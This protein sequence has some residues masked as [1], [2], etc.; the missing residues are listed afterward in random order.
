MSAP[1]TNPSASPSAS[2]SVEIGASADTAYAFVTDL[3][4]MATVTAEAVAMRW[5]SGT[6]ATPGAVFKGR[7]RNGWRRWSTRCEVTDAEPGRTFAFEVSSFG[8]PVARWQ[9]DVEPLGADRCRVTES[10]WDQRPAWFKGPAGLATG[11]PDRDAGNAAHIDETLARLKS[12][13][14]A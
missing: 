13:L 12:A 8:I 11:V 2:G 10:T 5:T 3:D 14:E 1:A 7:N 6:A 9:Y 4:R